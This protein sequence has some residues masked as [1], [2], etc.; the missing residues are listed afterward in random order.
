MTQDINIPPFFVVGT[1]KAGTTSLHYW[2]AQQPDICLPRLKETHFFS[3]DEKYQLGIEWYIDQFPK[4]RKKS[5][6]GE[7]APEYMFSKKAPYRIRKWINSPKIIFIF[8]HPIERAF[9]QYLMAVSKGYEKL[10]FRRA[11][12]EESRRISRDQ[13][14]RSRYGY[15][16]RGRYAEQIERYSKVFPDAKFLFI[17]FDD[18]IAQGKTGLVTYHRICD[19]IGLKSSPEIANRNIKSNPA[20]IPK[21]RFL[22]DF[23][24]RP[25]RFKKV[26][27]TLIPNRNIKERI[28]DLL[29]RLNQQRFPKPPMGKVPMSMIDLTRE[30]IRRL[31]EMT[32]LNLSDWYAHTDY[33][34]SVQTTQAKLMT[35]RNKT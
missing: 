28:A 34:V 21:F 11:L 22:R 30:E 32:L 7:I 9:S 14:A 17:K 18:L 12:V 33:L 23:L 15:M 25:S 1:Q 19:F 8:R 2:L 13:V 4:C 3:S 35:S 31:Q 5:V 26:L 6:M 10:T 16:T 29:V 27:G 24:Y 20:S